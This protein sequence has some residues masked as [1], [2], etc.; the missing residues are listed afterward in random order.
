MIALDPGGKGPRHLAEET[1]W[2]EAYRQLWASRF[3]A[4]DEIV[5]ELKRHIHVGI[6][7]SFRNSCEL[8]QATANTSFN[9]GRIGAGHTSREIS[10]STAA[11]RVREQGTAC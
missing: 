7:N 3:D 8:S 4:L 5:E 11:F 2:I 6:I 1:A 10:Y 9:A